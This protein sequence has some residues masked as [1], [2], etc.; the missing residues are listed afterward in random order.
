MYDNAAWC[1]YFQGTAKKMTT[2]YGD[3]FWC[4]KNA[5]RYT[6]SSEVFAINDTDH[7]RI[8]FRKLRYN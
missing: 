3:T 1:D 5:Q 6:S 2:A 7:I 8:V 4:V